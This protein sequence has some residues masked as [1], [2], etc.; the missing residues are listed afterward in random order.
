[1]AFNNI[2][3]KKIILIKT[4]YKTHNNNFLAII[5]IFITWKHYSKAYKH[6]IF[7]FT[8]YN[9]FC[10]FINTKNLSSKQV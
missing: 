1:M 2:F 9:N 5:R 3:L 10:Y 7:D 4:W 8:D 6:E